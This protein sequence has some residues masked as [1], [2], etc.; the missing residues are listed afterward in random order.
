MEAASGG[1]V[2]LVGMATGLASLLAAAPQD[3][4]KEMGENLWTFVIALDVI[5][6]VVVLYFLYRIFR[7]KTPPPRRRMPDQ[8][9]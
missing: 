8:R 4:V 3:P 2:A 7:E 1:I 9:A 6:T 5:N